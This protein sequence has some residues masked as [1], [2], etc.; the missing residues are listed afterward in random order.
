MPEQD[1]LAPLKIK[2]TD[3]DCKNGLHCFRLNQ[4]LKKQNKEGQCRSCGVTL[5]DWDRVHQ[6]N[7]NDTHYTFEALKHELVRHHFWHVTICQEAID[8]AHERGLYRLRADAEKIIGKS[9][10]A[11]KPYRDGYQTPREGS[12]EIV[13]YAQHATAACCRKCIE[14]WHGIPQGRALASTEVAYLQDLI[15]RY[16]EERVQGLQEYGDGNQLRLDIS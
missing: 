15:M 3:S 7:L 5:V 2:C 9:V 12:P 6:R 13:H 16:I 10:S 4:K 14:Y 8:H 11:E 1:D